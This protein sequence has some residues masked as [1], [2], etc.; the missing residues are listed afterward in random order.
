MCRV[1]DTDSSTTGTVQ[2]FQPKLVLTIDAVG[3]VPLGMGFSEETRRSLEN[4][5]QRN[6]QIVDEVRSIEVDGSQR[7]A[8]ETKSA[9]VRSG[10]HG[11]RRSVV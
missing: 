3:G 6:M 11:N 4:L 5:V 7:E 10:T 2:S 1:C 8:D 9:C